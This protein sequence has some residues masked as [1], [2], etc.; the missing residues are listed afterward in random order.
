MSE[1]TSRGLWIGDPHFRGDSV[2]SRRDDFLEAICGKLDSALKM[3]EEEGVDYI[4]IL[5]DVL[6]VP[7]PAGNVRNRVLDIL[8]RHQRLPIYL[9]VGNHDVFGHNRQTLHRTAAGTLVMSGALQMVDEEP[10]FGVYFGHYHEGIE[11]DV[12][13]SD[14]PVWAMHAF[15]MPHHYVA[16]HVTIDDFPTTAKVVISG[17]YHSGYPITK[18]KD[19][20]IFANPGSLGRMSVSDAEHEVCVALVEVGENIANVQY[21]PVPG[22]QPASVVFDMSVQDATKQGEHVDISVF[23]E[24]LSSAKQFV[25]D[26]AS[27]SLE[28]VQRA[29]E[30]HGV[31]PE[32]LVEAR[33]RILASR[34][35]TQ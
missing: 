16:E 1:I 18:R 31:Q 21:L 30:H 22:I 2:S 9:T 32:I 29:A 35:Q 33:R 3:A 12:I 13:Q 20:V 26:D 7:E 11:Q 24:S 19:G 15:I 27:D 28:L 6:H 10:K 17:H 8:M 14:M 23:V 34:E 5:G 25:C 4:G